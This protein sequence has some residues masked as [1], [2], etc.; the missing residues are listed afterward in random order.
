MTN[1]ERVVSLHNKMRERRKMKERRVNRAMGAGSCALLAFI[2][3]LI[4]REEVVYG[5]SSTGT[6]TGSTFVFQNAGS[7]VLLALAAFMLG[8][9]ITVLCIRMRKHREEEGKEECE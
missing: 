1:E 7:Y 4:S 3:A 6:Y 2:V 8:V 9:V 5:G